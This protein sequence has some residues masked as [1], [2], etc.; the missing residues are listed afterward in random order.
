M[1][2]ATEGESLDMITGDRTGAELERFVAIF[3]YGRLSGET[4]KELAQRFERDMLKSVM[5]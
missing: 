2:C 4:D 3:G 5:P 1:R